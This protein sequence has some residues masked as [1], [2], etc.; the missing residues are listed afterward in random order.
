MVKQWGANNLLSSLLYY[1]VSYQKYYRPKYGEMVRFREK[2]GPISNSALLFW[3]V[4][5]YQAAIETTQ[6][7]ISRV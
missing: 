6:A 4:A 7:A 1:P 5:H 2:S 3:F